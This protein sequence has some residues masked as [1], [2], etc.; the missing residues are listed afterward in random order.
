MASD[1]KFA[2]HLRKYVQNI[3]IN[4]KLKFYVVAKKNLNS[5]PIMH[6]NT[7]LFLSI[8]L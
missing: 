1:Y 4:Y 6:E 8:A 5:L 3:W 2:D 7:D